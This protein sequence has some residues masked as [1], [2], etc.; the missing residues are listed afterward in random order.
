VDGDAVIAASFDDTLY[1]SNF[2]N[3]SSEHDDCLSPGMSRV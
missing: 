3:Q 2:F 1:V